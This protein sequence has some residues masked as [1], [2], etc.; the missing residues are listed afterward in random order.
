MARLGDGSGSNSVV[1]SLLV[2]LGNHTIL[3]PPPY[4][5]P[6]PKDQSLR[7]ER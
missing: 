1:H 6:C 5:G 2:I 7:I 4:N 3:A